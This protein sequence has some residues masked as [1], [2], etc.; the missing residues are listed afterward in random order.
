MS[1]ADNFSKTPIGSLADQVGGYIQSVRSNWGWFAFLGV[2]SLIAGGYSLYA[3]N[4]SSVAVTLYIGA[5]MVLAGVFQIVLGFKAKTWGR[6]FWL[7]F[8]GILYVAAGVITYKDPTT[9]TA[10]MTLVLGV[11]FVVMGIIRFVMTLDMPKFVT[12]WPFFLSALVT[13][14]VGVLIVSGWPNSSIYTLGTFLGVDL[15]FAGVAWL[16]FAFAIKPAASSN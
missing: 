4:V 2:L 12:R 1:A 7:L 3:V 15:L 9:A 13:T 8:V 10:V 11:S 5:L 16:M 14:L 6:F